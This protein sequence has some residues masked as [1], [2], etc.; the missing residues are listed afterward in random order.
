M[1]PTEVQA[2]T[3]WSQPKTITKIRS[4]L[5]LASY[6]RGSIKDFSLV[7][8]SMNKLKK[9]EVKFLWDD[10]CELSFQSRRRV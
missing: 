7:A 4:F 5:G 8:S 3:E 9:K 10:M 2:V 6:Y 1:D